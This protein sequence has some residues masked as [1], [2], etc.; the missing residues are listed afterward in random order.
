MVLSDV[1]VNDDG[2]LQARDSGGDLGT[3]F[4]REGNVLL[5]QRQGQAD[6]EGAP[7]P[8]PALAVHQRREKTRY[9]QISLDG[10]SF[11]RIGGDG[12]C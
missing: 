9:F 7:R 11:T 1:A 12:G 10:H 5:G 4:G 8:A 3:L 2:S 6:V